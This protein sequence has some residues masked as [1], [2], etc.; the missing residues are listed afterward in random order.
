MFELANVAA[1]HNCFINADPMWRIHFD[2]GVSPQKAWDIE[3]A[4]LGTVG[5]SGTVDASELFV[6]NREVAVGLF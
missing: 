4:S 2:M 3:Y 6:S 1:S 5:K